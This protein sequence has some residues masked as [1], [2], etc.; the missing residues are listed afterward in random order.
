MR[1]V[2]FG[3]GGGGDVTV[4]RVW[5]VHGMS[6]LMGGVLLRGRFAFVVGVYIER[7][8]LSWLLYLIDYFR[9]ITSY[10]RFPVDQCGEKEAGSL[11]SMLII[12]SRTG[13][14]R[15]SSLRV[16]WRTPYYPMYLEVSTVI[17][18]QNQSLCCQAT[19]VLPVFQIPS[20]LPLP[21]VFCKARKREGE[22]CG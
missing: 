7:A 12:A 4:C 20:K 17:F 22:K 14:M 13:P 5:M 11:L 2:F 15:V 8:E 6:L 1:G 9:T 21:H 19:Y 10:V 18:P 3:G 16:R